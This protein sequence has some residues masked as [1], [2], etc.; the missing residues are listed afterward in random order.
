EDKIIELA[1]STLDIESKAISNLK[2]YIDS[3][4]VLSVK[5]IY[6]SKGRVVVTGIGKSANIANK[7]VATFNSTG[8]PAIFMHAADAIHGDLG[9]IQKDDIVICFSKSGNTDEIKVLLPIIKSMNNK[10]IAI[11][12]NT[13]SY[14]GQHADFVLNAYV[15]KEACPNNLAPT[16]STSA[17]LALSDALAICLLDYRGFSTEDFAKFHP[18]GV[19]GRK[20]LLR[21]EDVYKKNE[22]P[23]VK[24]KANIQSVIL[25]IS[26]KRL[27][28]TAVVDDDELVGII[29]DGDLRRMLQNSGYDEKIV[30][31]DIMHK[32]PKTIA[33][34]IMAEEALKIME[35]N[36]IS[37]LIIADGKKYLGII[38]IHDILKENI[39]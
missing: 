13:D 6:E 1:K 23:S 33:S 8:T 27:G 25:E 37:Q 20:L 16:T 34:N 18:G 3:S 22:V 26:G 5:A 17:Q 29:T 38:H 12:G 10:L 24:P 39:I 7:L 2:S 30:A 15:E 31:E 36:S 32:E 11:V 28:A 14:L 21:V 19:L 9:I 4:F 35:D